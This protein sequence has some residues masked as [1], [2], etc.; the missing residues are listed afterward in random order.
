MGEKADYVNERL[1]PVSKKRMK[2][3]CFEKRIAIDVMKRHEDVL[4]QFNVSLQHPI[5]TWAEH[6]WSH[7]QNMSVKPLIIKSAL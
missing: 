6:G 1:K 7:R 5:T 2:A 3:S 4:N